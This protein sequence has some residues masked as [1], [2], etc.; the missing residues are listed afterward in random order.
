MTEAEL[1]AAAVRWLARRL[2]WE[3]D[4]GRLRGEPDPAPVTVAP[5][6]RE[7]LAA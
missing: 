3:R 4:L 7:D 5:R 2:A 6:S 1:R